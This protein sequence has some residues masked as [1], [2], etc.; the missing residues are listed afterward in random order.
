MI[1]K[2]T[3]VFF[4]SLVFCLVDFVFTE[5]LGLTNNKNELLKFRL[6]VLYT[7]T[8]LL[9]SFWDKIFLILEI[10]CKCRK[11]VLR[12]CLMSV[13]KMTPRFFTVLLMDKVTRWNVVSN[14]TWCTLHDE[15]NN[16][17]FRSRKLEMIY[18]SCLIIFFICQFTV[19]PLLPLN[20]CIFWSK[21]LQFICTFWTKCLFFYQY[22]NPFLWRNTDPSSVGR[23]C[24]S[25]PWEVRREPPLKPKNQILQTQILNN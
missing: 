13:S 12:I 19:L 23:D 11:A 4:C 16:L 2:Y 9:P 1:E 7:W 15:Y 22:G 17:R 14:Q 5:V 20:I 18:I 25:L 21:L 10:L 8:S 3:Q 24:Y 6:K